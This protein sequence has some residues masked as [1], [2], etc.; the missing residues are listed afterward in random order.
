MVFNKL[1]QDYQFY[2]REEDN[3]AHI[4]IKGVIELSDWSYVSVVISKDGKPY[5]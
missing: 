1:P 5:A 2:Q 4:K 3:Y